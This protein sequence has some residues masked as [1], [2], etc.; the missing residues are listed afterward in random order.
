MT[1]TETPSRLL[2][3]NDSLADLRILTDMLRSR[4]TPWAGCATDLRSQIY[5][6]ATRADDEAGPGGAIR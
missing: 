1:E 2:I 3:D 6:A 4:A 5:G